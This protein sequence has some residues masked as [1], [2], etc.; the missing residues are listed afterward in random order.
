[1]NRVDDFAFR[2]LVASL[3][4][5]LVFCNRDAGANA[6]AFAFAGNNEAARQ[7]GGQQIHLLL[8]RRQHYRR[9]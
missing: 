5:V 8:N 2:L 6:S 7:E 3:R 4:L 1:M 9:E